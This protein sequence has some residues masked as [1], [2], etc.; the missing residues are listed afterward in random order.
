MFG[1]AQVES[2]GFLELCTW[3]NLL[4]AAGTENYSNNPKQDEKAVQSW[5]ELQ[6][7]VVILSRIAITSDAFHTVI[8][9][10]VII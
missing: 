9:S 8:W 10:I 2:G 7:R 5:G 1:A 6:S 4:G 3:L